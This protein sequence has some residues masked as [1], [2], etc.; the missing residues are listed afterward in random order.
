MK[1]HAILM[2]ALGGLIVAIVASVTY[3]VGALLLGAGNMLPE[4][5]GIAASCFCLWSSSRCRKSAGSSTI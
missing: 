2:A 1:K 5:L 3:S 4:V